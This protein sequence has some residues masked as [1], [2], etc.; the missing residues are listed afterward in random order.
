MT[1][2]PQGLAGIR[3]TICPA[4]LE[5]SERGEAARAGMGCAAMAQECRPGTGLGREPMGALTPPGPSSSRRGG[6]FQ[7]WVV[8]GLP[9]V[10]SSAPGPQ[11][12]QGVGFS[13]GGWL[14]AATAT[15]PLS[16]SCQDFWAAPQFLFFLFFFFF[17]QTRVFTAWKNLAFSSFPKKKQT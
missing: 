5:S 13:P 3:E 4:P 11:C 7:G 16:L 17:S 10:A 9:R 15:Q 1:G 2:S 6:G 14:E 12:W 8:P